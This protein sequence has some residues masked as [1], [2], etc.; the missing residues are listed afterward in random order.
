[1]GARMMRIL[2]RLWKTELKSPIP[3]RFGI[4]K[5]FF[6]DQPSMIAIRLII[7]ICLLIVT[8]VGARQYFLGLFFQPDKEIFGHPRDYHVNFE[9]IYFPSEGVYTLHGYLLKPAG[10]STGLVIHCHGNASNITNHFSLTLY[11]VKG[12][13]TVLTFDYR[14]YGQSTKGRPTPEGII[15]DTV[16]AIEFAERRDDLKSLPMAL[17]GQSLGGAA[18][19]GAMVRRS[20][21]RALFLEATFTTYQA[22]A[23]R[24][25]LGRLLYP[26]TYLIPNKGPLQDVQHLG[27]RPL[28][29]VHG[30]AD[31]VV[32]FDFSEKLMAAASE[33]KTYLQLLG[34]DHLEG[35]DAHPEFESTVMN[36]LAMSFK[37]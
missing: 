10:A 37:N 14:G 11:L 18:A 34:E 16:S 32:P 36:F 19:A 8:L 29:I 7:L 28:L 22:M 25:S 13:Y 20:E 3:N 1:M 27:G 26:V 6:S 31:H 12:G 2:K 30:T 15:K 5:K 33:P 9:E 23:R 4:L 24:T 21:I 35:Y 17:Y